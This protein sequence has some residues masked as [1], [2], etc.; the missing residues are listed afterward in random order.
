MS[1]PSGNLADARSRGGTGGHGTVGAAE[2]RTPPQAAPDLV[3]N[4]AMP[5][6]GTPDSPVRITVFPE[7]PEAL[8]VLVEQE[9]EGVLVLPAL[10][11]PFDRAGVHDAARAAGFL[12]R[13]SEGTPGRWKPV[14]DKAAKDARADRGQRQRLQEATF[15]ALARGAEDPNMRERGDLIQRKQLVD[16]KLAAAKTQ[17]AAAKS[18]AWSSTTRMDP[19]AFRAQEEEVRQLANESQAIQVRLGELRRAEK[20]RNREASR[21]E[22][23]RFGRRLLAAARAMLEPE[24]YER[25]VAAAGGEDASDDASSDAMGPEGADDEGKR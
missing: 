15:A 12:A 17:V 9:A 2:A 6:P 5:I 10:P 18:A 1:A 20:D 4:N 11:V 13:V 8:L 3:R 21:V 16:E 24:V 14:M 23:E 25:L 22:S 7:W 19:A